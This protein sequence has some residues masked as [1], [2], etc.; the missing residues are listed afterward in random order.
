M[1]LLACSNV[2]AA[3]NTPFQLLDPITIA[4]DD[5]DRI[6]L[7]GLA[8]PKLDPFMDRAGLRRL[9]EE[10]LSGGFDIQAENSVDRH[11]RT[12][13]QIYLA[14]GRWLN[15]EAVARGLAR[16]SGQ[17]DSSPQILGQ[18]LTIETKA[19]AAGLGQ[20]GRA[21]GF[22][23]I[24]AE[25]FGARAGRFMLVRGRILAVAVRSRFTY[26]NFGPD[27]RR[28][29]TIGIPKGKIRAFRKAGIDPA[30]LAGREILVRGW[31]EWRNGPFIELETPILLQIL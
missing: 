10:A 20:W 27:W 16:V 21:S 11:G 29:F 18:L 24:A 25:P 19:R 2:R 9:L 12:H 7:A 14:D 17:Y 5:G 31:V 8:G 30:R 15:G 3:E 22:R 13:A 1:A 28:D 23:V 4:R 6:R 26:L